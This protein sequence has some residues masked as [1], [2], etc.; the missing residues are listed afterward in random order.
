MPNPATTQDVAGRWRPLS[1]DEQVLADTRLGDA[2]LMLKR[3]AK[4]R[5]VE[6]IDAAIA[7]DE[8][9]RDDV[10]RVLATAVIRVFKNPDGLN[11]E[12]T[13]DYEYER[14]DDST[15]GELGFTDDELDE[16]FPGIGDD[17][18]AFSIDML[19]DYAARFE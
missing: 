2:W 6:D 3:R 11:K 15:N 19:G 9:L 5:G 18:R 13:D 16:L 8:D 7:A 1:T 10:I 17:G 4:K 12:K 14:S